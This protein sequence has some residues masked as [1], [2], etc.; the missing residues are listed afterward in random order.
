MSL[1]IMLRHL[2][3]SLIAGVFL[4]GCVSVQPEI[5]VGKVT[6]QKIKTI[7][8]VRFSQVS[9]SNVR[10]TKALLTLSS[11]IRDSNKAFQWS[12]EVGAPSVNPPR[13]KDPFVNVSAS[14]ITLCE[15]LDEICSQSGWTYEPTMEGH[16]FLFHA[17]PKG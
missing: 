1:A 11:A 6:A 2:T 9:F 4:G 16:W 14:N 8:D 10:M 3:V 17:P 7:L 5:S 12:I 15:L 13:P